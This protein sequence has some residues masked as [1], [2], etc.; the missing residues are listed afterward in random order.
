MDNATPESI[1]DQ[2]EEIKTQRDQDREKTYCICKTPYNSDFPMIGC[3]KC[4][5]WFHLSC[6]NINTEQAQS[7]DI[8]FCP[9]CDDTRTEVITGNTKRL[10]EEV[11]NIIVIIGLF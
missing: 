11:I 2:L 1:R 4:E 3:D 10:S 6:V 8:Y 5:G 9:S 7:I